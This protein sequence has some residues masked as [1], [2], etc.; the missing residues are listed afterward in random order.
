MG[1]ARIRGSR[2][3]VT[4]RGHPAKKSAMPDNGVVVGVDGPLVIGRPRLFVH[5]QSKRISPA[6]GSA[7]IHV[8]SEQCMAK[9]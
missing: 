1:H 8:E 2:G 5:G 4:A 6:D 3:W 7:G 9:K